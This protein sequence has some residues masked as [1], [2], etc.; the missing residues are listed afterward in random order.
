M[1]ERIV[2]DM[3]DLDIFH[4]ELWEKYKILWCPELLEIISPIYEIR[5]NN[6]TF[7]Q[8]IFRIKKLI[9]SDNHVSVSETMINDKINLPTIDTLGTNNTVSKKDASPSLE[10]VID[11]FIQNGYSEQ[12]AIGAFDSYDKRGWKAKGGKL[13]SCLQKM[14]RLEIIDDFCGNIGSFGVRNW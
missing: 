14:V 10:D 13:I 11:Y 7:L 9:L 12:A 6:L 8:D 4:R 1:F 3:I 5:E 2:S